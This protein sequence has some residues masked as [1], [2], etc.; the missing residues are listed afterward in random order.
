MFFDRISGQTDT[1]PYTLFNKQWVV[2]ADLGYSSAPFSIS[3]P[4]TSNLS[5]IKFKNNFRTIL[6]LGLSYKWFSLRF[7]IPLPGFTRSI[8]KFGKTNPLNIGFD[9]TFKKIYCDI[10]LRSFKGYAITDAFNWNDSLNLAHPNEIRSSTQTSSFSIYVWYF[11]HKDF[12]I[13]A[14][15]GKTA[16]YNKKVHTWYLK[17][18]LNLFSVDNNRESV[19]PDILYNPLKPQTMASYYSA[20]DIGVVPGYA[21]VDRFKNWQV[22]VMGG[23]G[24]VIQSKFFGGTVPSRGFLGLAPR[25]DI[26]FLGGYSVPN[27]FVFLLTDFDNKSIRFSN[28]VYRQHFYAIK[29]VAGKRFPVK[30]KKRKS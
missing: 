30:T 6:G 11:N 29:I 21:Y 23:L 17:N 12:K 8:A 16:H 28:L 24:G 14:L 5:K 13:S 10:D 2:Y 27:Y 1:L 9:F 7:G 26:R 20:L 22:A 25:Y 3:Y 15:K 4:Y 19:I 18:T